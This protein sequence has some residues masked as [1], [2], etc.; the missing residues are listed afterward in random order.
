MTAVALSGV[1]GGPLSGWILKDF[2]G[3]NNWAGWQWLFLLEGLPS[4]FMGIA[5]FFYLND[6]IQAAKWLT[7]EEKRILSEK[8]KEE[9]KGV[10]D[11]G[12]LHTLKNKKVWIM[13]LIYFSFVMGLYG[14]GFWLPQLIKSMG[15]K[16][17]LNIGL[18]TAIPYG[19]ATIVMVVVGRNSDRTGERRWHTAIVAMLG[20]I[21]LLL[22]GIFSDSALDW[23]YCFIPELFLGLWSSLPLLWTMPTAF[24]G[25]TA[26]AAG[27]AMINSLGNLAGFASPFMV[28]YL[29]DLT[30]S[31]TFGLHL[32]A[33][34]LILG[35]VIVL[36]VVK[37]PIK[38]R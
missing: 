2:D 17:L 37:K 30:G 3:L 28:G 15:V 16:D 9:N 19:I 7:E 35:G 26:A 34:F 32:I 29:K 8:I 25:G 33:I 22:T 5:V 36:L 12:V 18:L 10:I 20:G 6:S 23:N 14:V 31:T 13:G 21:G 11:H 38:L 24:L 1:V 4:V 27:I